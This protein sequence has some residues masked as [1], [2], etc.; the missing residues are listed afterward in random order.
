MKMYAFPF[1]WAVVCCD[2]RYNPRYLLAVL[3]NVKHQGGLVVF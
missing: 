2:N 3:I 1:K